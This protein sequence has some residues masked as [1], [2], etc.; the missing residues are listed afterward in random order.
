MALQQSFINQVNALITD[1]LHIIGGSRLQ[2]LTTPQRITGESEYFRQR[3][4]GKA[5]IE[6]VFSAPI[7]P[8]HVDYQRRLMK[9]KK[10]IF[11]WTE[12]M[13]VEINKG[14]GTAETSIALRSMEEC[15]QML[16][17]LIIEGLGAPVN[18]MDT[19]ITTLPERQYVKYNTTSFGNTDTGLNAAKISEAV[20]KLRQNNVPP[21]YV[22]VASPAALSQFGLDEKVANS[23]YNS[24]QGNLWT[25]QTVMPKQMFGYAGVDAYVWSHFVDSGLD[26][27]ASTVAVEYAYIFSPRYVYLGTQIGLFMDQVKDSQTFAD[28]YRVSGTYGVLRMEEKAVVRL[29]IEQSKLIPTN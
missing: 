17:Q 20:V 6:D 22:C 18:I 14:A 9:P 26:I 8:V 29:E 21:P 3:D 1:N 25:P 28:N 27:A 10:I 24:H 15:G 13:F 7:Q 2:P 5:R 16:D 19:G 23:L 4:I 11:E 12:D